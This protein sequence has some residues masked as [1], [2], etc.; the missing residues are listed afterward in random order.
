MINKF[1]SRITE[2]WERETRIVCKYCGI[3]VWSAST[4]MYTPKPE[5][6][7][8]IKNTG[9]CKSCSRGSSMY[10]EFDRFM[11]RCYIEENGYPGSE[12]YSDKGSW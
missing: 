9:E 6:T 1:L 3:K 7:V 2:P 5:Q 4:T 12:D 8:L 10:R 11:Y